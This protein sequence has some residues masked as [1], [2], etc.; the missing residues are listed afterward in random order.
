MRLM[1]LPGDGI[2]PEIGAGL[3]HVLSAANDRFGLGLTLETAEVGLAALTKAGTTLPETVLEAA[4]GCEGIILGP[5]STYEYPPASEGGI[6]ASAAFRKEL[7]LYANI[8]PARTRPGV[9][10]AASDMDLVVVRENTEGF[11]ADRTMFA[12]SGEFM[13]TE[14]LALAL[15]KV[16]R[17]GSARIARQACELAMRRAKRLTIVHKAN[18]LK[19]TDGLFH[20]TASKV[21]EEYREIE[22][23]EVLVD[24]AASLLVRQ[25][26][27]FDVIV[28]TNMFGDI[29]SNLTAE[30]SGGLGLAASL[31]AGDQY[32]MAQASHGSAP[33]IAGRD[34]ANPSSLILSAAMLFDW[35]G[36]RNG[37]PDL[38]SAADAIERAVDGQLAEPAGRTRDLGG[39]FGTQAFAQ[40]VAD[41]LRAGHA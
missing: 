17:A 11:Y 6:N 21:A 28:T 34:V 35:L 14:D 12:G 20:K 32:A 33:D 7:D 29:L 39:D 10:A 19:L 30:L 8:R 2:G 24:A 40:A 15:R 5:L 23:D 9:R 38:R 16:S 25:P 4:R 13:P 36:R 37:V 18:V 26:S 27:R 3:R 22:V 1:L 41:R 31:N